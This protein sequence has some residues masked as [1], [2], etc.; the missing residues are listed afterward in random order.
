MIKLPVRILVVAALGGLAFGVLSLSKIGSSPA[1]D[2]A[3]TGCSEPGQ[4][5]SSQAGTVAGNAGSSGNSDPNGTVSTVV[6]PTEGEYEWTLER[7]LLATPMPMTGEERDFLFKHPALEQILGWKLSDFEKY[8][9]DPL[10]LKHAAEEG[11]RWRDL[12]AMLKRQS[13]AG[14]KFFATEKGS[15]SGEPK[16]PSDQAGSEFERSDFDQFKTD[17]KRD[18]A[19]GFAKM[20]QWRQE[21]KLLANYV[22][23]MRKK[24]AVQGRSEEFER[25]VDDSGS[26]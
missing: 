6:N 3:P 1:Q 14:A 17:L 18:P 8:T 25:A 7:M 4:P 12:C 9:A 13:K 11:V 16:L 22:E 10:G 15:K 23:S 2:V 19:G 21:I 26:N 5:G 20:S 24:A